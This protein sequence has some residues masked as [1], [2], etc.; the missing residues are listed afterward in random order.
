MKIKILN[1][2]LKLGLSLVLV[3]YSSN[4]LNSHLL[5]F[6]SWSQMGYVWVSY[7]WNSCA[8]ILFGDGCPTLYRLFAAPLASTLQMSPIP[9]HVEIA[10][11]VSW[12]WEW[13]SIPLA[14][15]WLWIPAPG[16]WK[17]KQGRNRKSMTRDTA[18]ALWEEDCPWWNPHRLV[19]V[20]P[21]LYSDIRIMRVP[22][23]LPEFSMA[24]YFGMIFIALN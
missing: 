12:G 11:N 14:C 17:W 1:L 9:T 24:S 13:W 8:D 4:I 3:N 5:S 18:Q 16:L 2:E 6:H 22:L 19:C 21:L 7:S 23:Y 20:L 15:A 10:K